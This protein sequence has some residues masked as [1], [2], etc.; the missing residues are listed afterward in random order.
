MF[1]VPEMLHVAYVWDESSAR[2]RPPIHAKPKEPLVSE[3]L[4]WWQKRGKFEDRFT[5]CDVT[6]A[7]DDTLFS[8]DGKLRMLPNTM[9]G[10]DVQ[11]DMGLQQ[12]LQHLCSSAYFVESPSVVTL[13]G[14]VTETS[15]DSCPHLK[16]WRTHDE[17]CLN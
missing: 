17:Y 12:T 7:P 6:D 11:Q 10:I 9:C 5:S 16:S 4:P 1:D 15:V 3:G 13:H 14:C 8:A 2:A